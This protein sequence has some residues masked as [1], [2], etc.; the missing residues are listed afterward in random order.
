[1]ARRRLTCHA[2]AGFRHA[3]GGFRTQWSGQGRVPIPFV[4]RAGRV[5]TELTRSCCASMTAGSNRGVLECEPC[6]PQRTMAR[7]IGRV[8]VDGNADPEL[9]GDRSISAISWKAT[10]HHIWT[11]LYPSVSPRRQPL[12]RFVQELPSPITV[13]I[14]FCTASTSRGSPSPTT[15]ARCV[16]TALS[17]ERSRLSR[18][19]FRS[20]RRRSVRPR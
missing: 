10:R 1:M 9:P 7:E 5:G 2:E 6:P 20:S 8:Q 12:A 11:L 18:R 4:P 19:V 14:T 17:T 16:S 13:L 3:L 15:I